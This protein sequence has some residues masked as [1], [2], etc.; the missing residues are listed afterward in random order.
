[1]L[2]VCQCKSHDTQF[3]TIRFS[4]CVHFHRQHTLTSFRMNKVE[5]NAIPRP[6]PMLTIG[7]R[8]PRKTIPVSPQT[9]RPKPGIMTSH[10]RNASIKLAPMTERPN[11][12]PIFDSN[13][14]TL[15]NPRFRFMLPPTYEAQNL[16]VRM[17]P[18]IPNGPIS[19]QEAIEKYSSLL[20]AFEVTEILD[21]PEVY[22]VGF[23]NKKSEANL[24]DS[25]GFGFDDLTN[26][27]YKVQNGDHIIYRFEVQSLIGQGKHGQIFKCIDHKTKENC[28]LKILANIPRAHNQSKVEMTILSRLKK[29]HPN[30][31]ETAQI[32][33]QFRN[34]V[35][36]TFNILSKNLIQL[37]KLNSIN[38]LSPRLVKSVAIDVINQLKDIYSVGVTAHG[39]VLAENILLVPDTNAEFKLI[40]F[41]N[42]I[43]DGNIPSDYTIE[44]P[45]CY[46]SPESVL[47]FPLGPEFDIWCLGCLLF[48]LTTGKQLFNEENGNSKLGE[49]KTAASNKSIKSNSNINANNKEKPNPTNEELKHLWCITE[50]LGKPDEDLKKKAPK[51]SEFFDRSGQLK[52]LPNERAYKEN[53]INLKGLL[54]SEIQ[55]AD[56]LSRIFVWNHE[57][58]LTIEQALEHPYIKNTESRVS[59][60]E[61]NPE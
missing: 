24:S 48:Q 3:G 22:F 35:F 14:E 30:S 36:V 27:Y 34:H 1:M 19:P 49:S 47:G 38:T 5:T 40:D 4:F 59:E 6:P 58:R 51:K 9:S 18:V 8:T 50:L 41:S 45:R 17:S 54:G 43:L 13:G 31:I 11:I 57:K 55:L 46:Q 44:V 21:F 20:T 26:G 32:Y 29:L 33:F 37:M 10:S 42:S 56:F 61:Q 23:K 52:T 16:P 25:V 15:K 12:E 39:Q 2:Y 7:I 53:S 60:S 28:A